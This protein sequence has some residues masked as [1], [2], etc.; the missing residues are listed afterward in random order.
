LDVNLSGKYTNVN[1]HWG[2]A[3]IVHTPVRFMNTKNNTNF[4]L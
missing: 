1:Y 4:L 2:H 3:S